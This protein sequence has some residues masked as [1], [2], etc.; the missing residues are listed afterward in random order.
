MEKVFKKCY[1]KYKGGVRIHTLFKEIRTL[2]GKQ[3]SKISPVENNTYSSIPR[4]NSSS[5][6]FNMWQSTQNAQS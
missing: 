1:K 2:C 3:S 6:L 5:L 4:Y